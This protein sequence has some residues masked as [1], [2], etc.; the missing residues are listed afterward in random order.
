MS[1]YLDTML[2]TGDD[3]GY[4]KLWDLRDKKA[5][6]EWRDN[7][8]YISDLCVCPDNKFVL[9]PGGD[10]YLSVFNL[11]KGQLEARSDNMEHELLSAVIIKEGKKAVVGTSDGLLDIFNFGWWG[12]ISDKIPG[13]P[14]SVDTMV[15]VD[16]DTICTGSSDG[17]IRVVSIF[18]NKMLG[19]V[20]EHQ[21][22]PIEKI[23]LSR[24][25]K[26]LASCSHDQTVKFWD[27]GY[28]YEIDK[29]DENEPLD[30]N[31]DINNNNNNDTMET[32]S[33]SKKSK[34]KKNDKNNNNN[35]NNNFFSGLL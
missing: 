29:S 4:V 18:P 5:V 10:G 33:E 15:V 24:D 8:D 7:E 11:R 25:K 14:N 22:F 12:D 26:Y 6:H 34:K 13:H 21:D 1:T 35:N 32:E 30:E 19:I 16:N 28:L 2:I 23:K 3:D 31:T 9:A 17:L 27:V 20:G